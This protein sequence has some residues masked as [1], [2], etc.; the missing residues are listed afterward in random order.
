MK[1]PDV[2]FTDILG[3]AAIPKIG[4][5]GSVSTKQDTLVRATLILQCADGRQE[6][7]LLQLRTLEKSERLQ[8]AL[9]SL[10]FA[11]LI[12]LGTVFIPVLHFVLVPGFFFFGIYLFA[13]TYRRDTFVVSGSG[14]CPSCQNTF[15]VPAGPDT[16]PQQEVCQNC[17]WTVIL[18][19]SP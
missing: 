9:R 17:R 3:R 14:A 2:N 8:K 19:K 1:G 11:W 6:K 5:N 4:L 15:Q 10:G 18:K 7:G 13:K 16:W 12:S